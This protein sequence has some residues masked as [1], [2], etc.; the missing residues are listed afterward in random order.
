MQNDKRMLDKM[1]KN[2]FRI[3]LSIKLAEIIKNWDL[4]KN[5]NYELLFSWPPPK[6]FALFF[7]ILKKMFWKINV[8][9]IGDHFK[10]IIIALALKTAEILN[11][12]FKIWSKK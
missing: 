7:W 12:R 5:Y 1:K 2:S 3:I 6:A 8:V 9:W 10:P 11:L 4:K